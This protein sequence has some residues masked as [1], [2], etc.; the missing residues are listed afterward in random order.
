MNKILNGVKRIRLVLKRYNRI[1][2]IVL[3]NIHDK[4][5]FAAFGRG[6]IIESTIHVAS[7]QSVFIKENV[8]LRFGVNIINATGEKV[9]IGSHCALAPYVTIVTNSHRSTVGKT[10]F[11]LSSSHENDISG[12][13]V[14]EED[15]WIGTNATILQGVTLGRGSIVGAGAVVTKNVPP[16]AVVAGVPAKVI[17]ATFSKEDILEHEAHIYPLG[18]RMKEEEVDK[19]FNGPLKGLSIYGINPNRL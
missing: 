2:N 9:I 19:L 8:R 13:V 12:D 7:P 10:Q 4:T 5:E 18:E 11:Q 16:Y 14:I 6:S 15:V 3:A 1:V 17:A